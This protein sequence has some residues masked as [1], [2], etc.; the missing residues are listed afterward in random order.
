MDEAFDEE[1]Q[2]SLELRYLGPRM[3]IALVV[4][5]DSEHVW[6]DIGEK[7]ET[8]LPLSDWQADEGPPVAGDDEPIFIEDDGLD[9]DDRPLRVT[10]LHHIRRDPR[11]NEW[12][13]FVANSKSGD[14]LA[15]RVARRIE[16]G[17][18]VN[19]GVN[20]FLPDTH[21]PKA[22]L[23]DP[24]AAIGQSNNWRIIQIDHERRHVQIAPA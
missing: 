23:Q 6:L 5:V 13:T 11:S 4:R 17:F 1:L 3:R 22:M 24:Q 20:S 8:T 21:A 19:I 14:V 7:F 18:L 15:G 9:V 16:G 12:E 10:R 2:S